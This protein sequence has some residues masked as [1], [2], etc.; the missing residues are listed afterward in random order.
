M[1]VNPDLC[2][3]CRACSSVCPAGLITLRDQ[4]GRRVLRFSGTCGEDCSRCQEVCPPG[5]IT[6]REVAGM[7]GA[8]ELEFSLRRCAVC[9]QPFAPEKALAA[10]HPRVQE[11]LGG[12][13][14]PWWDLC[15]ACRRSLLASNILQVAGPL[16]A[17]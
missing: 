6:L 14:T 9:G 17:R 10:L 5:A 3:G 11:T 2:F 13:E 8:V 4:D 7:P 15:P 16:M 12:G 1:L